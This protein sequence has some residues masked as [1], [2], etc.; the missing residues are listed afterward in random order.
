M[1]CVCVCGTSE[2]FKWPT[3]I[4]FLCKTQRY[5]PDTTQYVWTMAKV[6][7]SPRS[8][9]KMRVVVGVQGC[10]VTREAQNIVWSGCRCPGHHSVV[11]SICILIYNV[12]LLMGIL[13]IFHFIIFLQFIRIFSNRQSSLWSYD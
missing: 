7:G 12:P 5:L 1:V 10:E 3:N 4:C 6:M 9:A 8:R 2:S 11:V 13:T